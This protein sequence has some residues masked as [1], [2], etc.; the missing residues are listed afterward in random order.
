MTLEQP[1]NALQG[2][3]DPIKGYLSPLVSQSN[4]W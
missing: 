4:L 2:K 1:K 3:L